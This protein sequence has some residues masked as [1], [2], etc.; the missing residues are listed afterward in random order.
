MGHTVISALGKM[1]LEECCEL[2]LAWPLSE[3]QNSQG[4]MTKQRL[5]EF[6]ENRGAGTEAKGYIKNH[7]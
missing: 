4:Y 6:K 2:R 3:F 5:K 7:P 1:R